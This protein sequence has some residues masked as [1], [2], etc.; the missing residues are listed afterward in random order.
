LS[1]S[2]SET[3]KR[4]YHWIG[5]FTWSIAVH[6]FIVS[7]SGSGHCNGVKREADVADAGAGGRSRKRGLEELIYTKRFELP[8]MP[9]IMIKKFFC[10]ATIALLR[11]SDDE[12]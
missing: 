6:I 9:L 7:T 4:Y 8:A 10:G 5:C 1:E 3:V 11:G 2:I 12:F